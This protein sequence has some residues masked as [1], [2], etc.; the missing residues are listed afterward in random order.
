MQDCVSYKGLEQF[1]YLIA[2]QNDPLIDSDKLAEDFLSM[3]DKLGLL[4]E[5]AIEPE[6]KTEKSSQE[7][8]Y[9]EANQTEADSLT[10]N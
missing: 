2:T 8:Y 6:L 4:M 7:Y 9:L 10:Q 1:D 3:Y 5:T